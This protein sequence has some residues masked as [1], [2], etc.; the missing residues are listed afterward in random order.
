MIFL[1]L[2]FF[3]SKVQV[4]GV[5]LWLHTVGPHEETSG[6]RPWTQAGQ[7]RA[8]VSL[9]SVPQPAAPLPTLWRR[10]QW[11]TS[12]C[13]WEHGCLCKL[14]QSGSDFGVKPCSGA[15]GFWNIVPLLGALF[16]NFCL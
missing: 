7:N 14:W 15:L 16:C 13:G 3:S 5:R 9:C 1:S 10:H 4:W 6:Q 2:F 8:S 11:W 12:I